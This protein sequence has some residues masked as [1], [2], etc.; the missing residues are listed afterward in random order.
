MDMPAPERIGADLRTNRILWL[1]IVM[2]VVLLVAVMVF[3]TSSGSGGTMEDGSLFFYLNAAISLGAIAAAFAIQRN[4]TDQLPKAGTYDE[5]AMLIRQRGLIA[6]ALMEASAF[7]AAI[8]A[9]LTGELI[10]LAF[11]VPFFAFAYL[12]FPTEAKYLYWLSLWRG[13]R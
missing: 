4:L 11:V 2:G 13:E 10:N 6:I 8:A 1:A 3:L 9:F 5:A 7:F 12:F